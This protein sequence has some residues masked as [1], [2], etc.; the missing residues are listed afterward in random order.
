LPIYQQHTIHIYQGGIEEI[1]TL[2]DMVIMRVMV[3]TGMYSVT[4]SKS[5]V[6]S[7]ILHIPEVLSLVEVKVLLCEQKI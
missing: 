6:K 5:Q 3:G 4:G 7:H 1:V 2:Y